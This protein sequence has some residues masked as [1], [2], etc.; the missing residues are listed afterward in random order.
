MYERSFADIRFVVERLLDITE[1]F[2]EKAFA[3]DDAELSVTT[4]RLCKKGV[5]IKF[6][7][8]ACSL[9]A[10]PRLVRLGSDQF[11]QEYVFIDLNSENKVAAIYVVDDADVLL[12]WLGANP[13]QTRVSNDCLRENLIEFLQREVIGSRAMEPTSQ[14]LDDQPNS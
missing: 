4:P 9:E 5:T 11:A 6:D 10:I 13:V 2:E 14:P 3:D 8:L 7:Y 12:G 1:R